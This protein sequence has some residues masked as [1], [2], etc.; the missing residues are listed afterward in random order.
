VMDRQ[1][2][3]ADLAPYFAIT[4]E[5]FVGPRNHNQVTAESYDDIAKT[6]SDIRLGRNDLKID[7]TSIADDDERAVYEER[8]MTDIGMVMTTTSGREQI[9]ELTDNPNDHETAV[10]PKF[11]D[12]DEDDDKDDDTESRRME[13]ISTEPEFDSYDPPFSRISYKPGDRHGT[14]ER[15]DRA[16]AHELQHAYHDVRDTE[17]SGTFDGGPDHYDS[18]GDYAGYPDAPNKERQAVG[19]TNT[20]PDHPTDD[21]GC[22]ENVYAAER[23]QMGDHFV[24]RVHYNGEFPGVESDPKG[25]TKLWQAF[26]ESP[27]N[28]VV[29]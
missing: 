8:V 12:D 6:Y 22:P 13:D 7:A 26:I 25:L 14:G 1:D 24:P 20:D 21:S 29:E 4:P 11:T 17:A 19:L 3:K 23:N 2:A 27:D 15:T 9:K 16:L 28:A 18:G 10:M 5:D